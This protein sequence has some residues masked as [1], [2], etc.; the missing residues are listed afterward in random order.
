[1]GAA[2][3]FDGLAEGG[4]HAHG[5]GR[6]AD[7]AVEQHG[8]KAHFHGL[9]GVA[10][11]ANARVDDERG[12]RQAL[13]QQA[14][15]KGVCE[16]LAGADGRAPGHEQRAARIQQAAAGHQI[17]R[18]VG[19]DGHSITVTISDDHEDVFY[20]EGFSGEKAPYSEKM[21]TVDGFVNTAIRMV[22]EDVPAKYRNAGSS[23]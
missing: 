19:K 10:G 6:V 7:G 13:A 18:A 20:G 14:Q 8:V 5:L 11:R 4:G 21:S 17:V 12:L 9:R 22:L 15:G 16:A 3:G 1:M 2:A 23:C